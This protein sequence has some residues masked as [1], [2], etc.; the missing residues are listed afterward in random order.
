[1]KV[2]LSPKE[3]KQLDNKKTSNNTRYWLLHKDNL[4]FEVGDVLIKLHKRYQRNGS[5]S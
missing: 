5:V 1:M 2:E 3:L 4:K